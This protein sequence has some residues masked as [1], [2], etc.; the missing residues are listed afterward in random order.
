MDPEAAKFIGTAL[1]YTGA[2]L[3]FIAAFGRLLTMSDDDCELD[4]EQKEDCKR[5]WRDY[6]EALEEENEAASRAAQAAT[7]LETA[8][9]DVN[10]PPDWIKE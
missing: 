3:S 8:G 7:E 2:I 4:E 9:I 1:A 10:Y 5:I 6:E